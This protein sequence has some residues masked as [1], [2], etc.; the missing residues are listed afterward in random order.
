MKSLQSFSSQVLQSLQNHFS[1]LPETGI[2][3]GQAV[4]SALYTFF[5][6]PNGPFR[7]LDI[8]DLAGKDDKL[9]NRSSITR[10]A[11]NVETDILKSSFGGEWS[12]EL[13]VDKGGY[14]IIESFMDDSNYKLNFITVHMAKSDDIPRSG[15]M[16][17][18]IEAFDLNCCQVAIDL[19]TGEIVATDAFMRFLED[20]TLRVSY[21]GTPMHSAVRLV[22]KSREMPF[23]DVDMDFELKK[24]QTVVELVHRCAHEKGGHLPNNLFSDIYKDRYDKVADVLDDY[25]D[26]VPKQIR[27]DKND[28]K[29][30]GS[31]E[32]LIL[33]FYVLEAKNY[34][35]QLIDFLSTRSVRTV[36]SNYEELL[37][38]FNTVNP[39][40]N[41][42]KFNELRR[43][44]RIYT[45]V[46]PDDHA[47]RMILL[48]L[49]YDVLK[50]IEK[51]E[52]LYLLTTLRDKSCF[53][54]FC[55]LEQ[56]YSPDSIVNFILTLKNL[57]M[58]ALFEEFENID[59]SSAISMK[60]NLLDGRSPNSQS[61]LSLNLISLIVSAF[62]YGEPDIITTW[63]PTMLEQHAEENISEGLSRIKQLGHAHNHQHGECYR[64]LLEHGISS[65]VLVQYS[66]ILLCRNAEVSMS[67]VR[68]LD[69]YNSFTFAIYR[70]WILPL[71][72]DIS[73]VYESDSTAFKTIFAKAYMQNNNIKQS[74]ML[75]MSPSWLQPYVIATLTCPFKMPV[76]Q[77]D[78]MGF[79]PDIPF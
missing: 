74:E 14:R 4:A 9:R 46:L 44:F 3:A 16:Y 24:L 35:Y 62:D 12:A 53:E 20:H 60:D 32:E 59:I 37:R 27:I 41:Q 58:G 65:D 52:L 18:L 42:D 1:P 76:E 29:P 70:D 66:N 30:F 26:I 40:D 71:T 63:L 75:E 34:H 50:D 15:F 43:I 61:S 67:A 64:R 78:G 31:Q 13:T 5:G 49:S 21:V 47:C 69:D 28:G 57:G 17:K 51:E 23:L 10:E 79:D 33:D 56:N 55:W 48:T 22:R 73:N 54:H 25:F 77:Q 8:F 72:T 36:F 7:D 68:R 39:F 2:A 38:A 45:G 11:G 19:A 6:I